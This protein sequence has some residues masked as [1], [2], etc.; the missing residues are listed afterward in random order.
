MT[1][2]TF[3]SLGVS[4]PL[5]RALNTENYTH[6]TPIQGK[7]IP[8]ILEGRDVL[9]LAQTGTG[10]TAA[11]GLPLLQRLSQ[12]RNVAGPFA[13]RALILAPTRELAVQISDSLKTYGCHL[14]LRSAVILGGVSQH[15]QVEAMRNGVD[16]LVATP[17]RLLDLVR[18]KYVR[19]DKATTLVL[20]EADRMFDMGFIKDVRKLI[21]FLPK[22]RLSLLFS[23]TM[24]KEVAHLCDEV[25]R[26]PVRIEVT[27]KKVAAEAIEQK[28]YHVAVADKRGLLHKLL[29]DDEAMRRVIVFTRTKHGAN[30]VED[31]LN[32]AGFSAD[33]IHGNKSQNAR[34]RALEA[35]RSGEI[36]LLVATDIAARGID[37][38]DITH[39]VN[40]DLPHEP[41]SYVHRIGRTA[42]AGS[43]GI[44]IAF[45]AA[46]ERQQ[47][48][49]IE[50][51]IRQ[52]LTVIGTPEIEAMPAQENH[53][54][55]H[56]PRG[57]RPHG[58]KPGGHKHG[59]HKP[60]GHKHD[61]NAHHA[62]NH[63]G[64][65]TAPRN[66]NN[67]RPRRRRKF[68]GSR[69]GGQQRAA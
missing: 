31:Q 9:G 40:F 51:L 7:A 20:D 29:R 37:I 49:A 64:D 54:P 47:L 43:A 60:H 57:H 41:E 45:C 25:L 50:K 69:N 19:L 23:A 21:S 10:K 13:T 15:K 6:P 46:E 68:R 58:H 2:V 8:A 1:D 36:R 61:G 56:N 35:F 66:D 28:L 30:K 63:S 11:F 18:Q 16:I 44:A 17:G 53:A 32:K 12:D 48:K 4:E 26:D 34:Q 5:L 22:Q 38:D 14:H 55:R 27:P 59:G 42:R 52:P 39:V 3:E 67:N 65:N 33:A 62:N 24:P